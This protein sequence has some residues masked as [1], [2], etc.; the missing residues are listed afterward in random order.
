VLA[1]PADYTALTTTIHEGSVRETWQLIW[2]HETRRAVGQLGVVF[3]LLW[4][5]LILAADHHGVERIPTHEHVDPL[6]TPAP[7]HQHAFSLDH[8]HDVADHGSASPEH[9]VA[10]HEPTSPTILPLQVTSRIIARMLDLAAP[11]VAA[12]ASS[13]LDN[14]EI[15]LLAVIIVLG[16]LSH[17]VIPGRRPRPTETAFSPPTPPP[18]GCVSL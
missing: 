10:D 13:L 15:P 11:T 12:V 16:A 9:S 18:V 5:L 4:P 6:G 3:A 17:A 7:E 2:C 1:A 14:N 8:A